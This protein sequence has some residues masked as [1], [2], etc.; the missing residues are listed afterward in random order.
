[1]KIS[2]FLNPHPSPHLA[3]RPLDPHPSHATIEVAIV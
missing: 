1:M 2:D 3:Q